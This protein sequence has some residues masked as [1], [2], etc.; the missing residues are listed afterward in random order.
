MTG[1]GPTGPIGPATPGAVDAN[2]AAPV[3]VA[4]GPATPGTVAAAARPGRSGLGRLV[5]Q[6]VFWCCAAFVFLAN[7]AVA[8]AEDRWLV[9]LL[10]ALTAAWALLAGMTVRETRPAGR[11]RRD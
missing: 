7:A 10:Q 11:S 1:D 2:T 5:D 4:P 9:A 8:A 3:T 6:P